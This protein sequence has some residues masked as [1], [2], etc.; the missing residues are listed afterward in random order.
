M[1]YYLKASNS[2][3]I[4]TLCDAVCVQYSRSLYQYALD[5]SWKSFRHTPQARKYLTYSMH[6]KQCDVIENNNAVCYCHDC[7]AC[8]VAGKCSVMLL[9]GSHVVLF[10]DSQ[11]N[12]ATP[13]PSVSHP[14]C[15]T[16]AVAY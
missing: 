2:S 12:T 11:T 4:S 3:Y 10:Y 5:A 9:M 6:S 16:N 7:A 8:A 15:F 14:S 13:M 1:G